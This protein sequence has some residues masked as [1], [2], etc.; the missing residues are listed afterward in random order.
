MAARTYAALFQVL[1]P[2]I[3]PAGF[4]ALFA[5]SVKLAQAHHPS[6]S[7]IRTRAASQETVPD[8]VIGQIVTSLTS[9]G[10]AAATEL[11][12]EVYAMFY[13]LLTKFI[14]E[15]LVHTIVQGALPTV[16]ATGPEEKK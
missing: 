9:L 15:T 2:V 4:R 1:A 14:G 12:T 11:A 16:G 5:R 10:P 6:L 7:S 3:G 13:E 8:H